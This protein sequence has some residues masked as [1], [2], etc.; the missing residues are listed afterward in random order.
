MISPSARPNPGLT[1]LV[2]PV[3]QKNTDKFRSQAL[4][5]VD[6][7]DFLTNSGRNE[8]SESQFVVNNLDQN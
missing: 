4:Y 2:I 5:E 8:T 7:E 6:I 3:A 1:A